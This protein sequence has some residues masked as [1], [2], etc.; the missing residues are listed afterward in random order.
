MAK[1]KPYC[2]GCKRDLTRDYDDPNTKGPGDLRVFLFQLLGNFS[3][4]RTL[5][6]HQHCIDRVEVDPFEY[7]LIP[8]RMVKGMFVQET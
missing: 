2:A 8:C 3:V 4:E 7:R 5:I 6:S 1:M